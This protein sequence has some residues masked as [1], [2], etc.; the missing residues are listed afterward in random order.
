MIQAFPWHTDFGLGSHNDTSMIQTIPW[1]TDFGLD[2]HKDPSMIQTFPWHTDFGLDRVFL[3]PGNPAWYLAASGKTKIL[4]KN[5]SR[6]ALVAE[7]A[8]RI[9]TR[10]AVR[11]VIREVFSIIGR[12]PDLQSWIFPVGLEDHSITISSAAKYLCVETRDVW[13]SYRLNKEQVAHGLPTLDVRNSGDLANSCPLISGPP[14]QPQRFRAY[15]GHCNNVQHPLWGSALTRYLR[16]LPPNYAD[17]R[18]C[19]E[20]SVFFNKTLIRK[21]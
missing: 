7:E 5:F 2:S 12:P 20:L 11:P 21:I 3:R 1:C 16:L 10:V 19:V 6:S 13:C 14:C 9:A 18:Y 15:S 4:A 8:S 17:G